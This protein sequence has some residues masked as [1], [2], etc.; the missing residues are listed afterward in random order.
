MKKKPY[1]YVNRKRPVTIRID[2]DTL[3]FFGE[4]SHETSVPYQ[5]LI[6]YYLGYCADENLILDVSSCRTRREPE[7]W[8]PRAKG[9]LKNR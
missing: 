2:D 3:A 5:T 4:L 6:N 7:D 1:R 8:T 9:R